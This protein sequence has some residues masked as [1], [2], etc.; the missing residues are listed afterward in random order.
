MS[1]QEPDSAK[2]EA[3]AAWMLSIVNSGM[4]SLMV[5]VGHRTGLFDTM[6]GMAPSSSAE[7]ATAAG[8]DERYVREWLG[9]MTTGRIVELDPDTGTYRLPPE[10][11]GIVTRAAGLENLASCAQ[12]VAMLGLVESDIVRSFREGGG[13][14]YARFPDFQHVMAEGSGA[15]HDAALIDGIIPLVD[16]LVDRLQA[17]IAVADVGC[18]SG[19]AI[20]LMA[21]AFPKSEFVGYDFS[22]AGIEAG[23][24]EAAAK[25]L[26]NATFEVRDAATL[27]GPPRFDLVT[28][29]DAIHDQAQP[30]RVL[31]GIA[32]C[33]REDGV[34]LCV[35]VRASSNV[36]E[37]LEHPLGPFLYTISCMH[38]MT[39]SLAQ[40]G[41]GLGAVWGEQKAL[42][43]LAEAAFGDVE[44]KTV[45]G[46]ILN[47]YYIARK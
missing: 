20:N 19:H 37:N 33:L 28:V 22:E 43:L 4:L 45:D 11:A 12:N 17:G 13:V 7:I 39:V 38:C 2:A 10:H 16:G 25:G 41:E 27:E 14:P 42:E 30:R 18:G 44:V 47:N 32:D 46:D 35:D 36:H 40:N 1:V 26:S 31:K 5:S 29:F 9:A 21:E 34:F 8:L 6:A 15:V 3:F 24:A 23:T